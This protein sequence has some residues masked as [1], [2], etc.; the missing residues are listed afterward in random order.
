MD[1]QTSEFFAKAAPL[2]LSKESATEQ[3]I[4][5]HG[6]MTMQLK[7]DLTQAMKAGDV[8]AKA[9]LRMAIAA[10][11]NAEVAGEA[12]RAL[13]KDEEMAV[14]TREVKTRRESATTY[15]AAGRPE[16][17]EKETAEADFLAR[18][19]PQPLTQDELADIV[20]G[21]VDEFTADNGAPPT[22]K[23]MGDLVRSVNEV[24]AGRA[25]G[26]AVAALVKARL[27]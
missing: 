4:E 27:A 15:A 12:V 23:N 21:K 3:A 1:D 14:L 16:L 9:T 25:E 5:R 11:Q 6:P 8:H 19:L 22:M 26:S 18:Y 17:A 13:T 24:V 20:N 2:D 10:M 7:A